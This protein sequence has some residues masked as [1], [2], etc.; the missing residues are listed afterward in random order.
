MD[1]TEFE[2]TVRLIMSMCSA[3]LT[4]KIT[5][6][7]FSANLTEIEE[8]LRMVPSRCCSCVAIFNKA[9]DR[10]EIIEAC[11]LHQEWKGHMGY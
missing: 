5:R 10:L 2:K 6:R 9:L 3:V 7:T 1:N 4:N 11:S 8:S